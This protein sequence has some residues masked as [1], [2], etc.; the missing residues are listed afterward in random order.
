MELYK[1]I[2]ELKRISNQQINVGHIIT[3][4]KGNVTIMTQEGETY[5]ITKSGIYKHEPKRR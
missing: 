4:D 1:L 5:I 3:A 2:E